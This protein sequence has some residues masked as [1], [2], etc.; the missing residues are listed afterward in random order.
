MNSCVL[1]AEITKAPELRYTQ[2]G[3]TPL[4]EM[5]VKF[6]G[7]RA[8]DPMETLKVV[9]WGNLAQQIQEQYHEGDQVAL[10]GRLS[11]T[12][13]DRP[14]GFKEKRAE[15]IVSRIHPIGLPLGASAGR[16]VSA[17]TSPAPTSPAPTSPA[18]TSS[19]PA[20]PAP[21]SPVE[22]SPAP[23]S[24]APVPS[25]QPHSEAPAGP[26]ELNYDDIPF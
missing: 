26:D 25:P 1:I 5:I 23:T 20:S 6:P 14:E 2:D 17:P 4:A 19:V 16:S 12:T 21:T 24:P 15:L 9:G 3:K 10:E 18:P 13:L 11:M 8:E 7:L 22:T